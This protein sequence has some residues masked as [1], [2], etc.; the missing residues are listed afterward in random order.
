[1]SLWLKENFFVWENEVNSRPG[2]LERILP[3]CLSRHYRNVE[4]IADE[5]IMPG[6]CVLST[7]AVKTLSKTSLKNSNL[8]C[9]QVTLKQT[10]YSKIIIVKLTDIKIGEEKFYKNFFNTSTLLCK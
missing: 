9:F 7:I 5:G 3:L 10:T 2:H 1:M 6:I 8:Y 4:V